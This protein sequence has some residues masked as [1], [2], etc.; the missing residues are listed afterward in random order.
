MENGCALKRICAVS[1]H[2]D[3]LNSSKFEDGDRKALWVEFNEEVYQNVVEDTM[4]L[5]KEH[6]RDIQQIQKEWTER[7]GHGMKG[8][9]RG[10]E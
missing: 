5:V 1:L 6:G 9:N 8:E 7:Y 3:A 2:F 10:R 4:H